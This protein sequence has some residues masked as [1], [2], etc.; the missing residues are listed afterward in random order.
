[1]A[2]VTDDHLRE[3]LAGV[4]NTTPYELWL[5]LHGPEVPCEGARVTACEEA[6]SRLGYERVPVHPI[7]LSR[8][9]FEWVRGHWP[10]DDRWPDLSDDPILL[11]IFDRYLTFRLACGA[12]AG[13]EH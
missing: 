7:R 6:L 3:L 1:M 2:A 5:M 10:S 11:E 8:D 4:G 9:G 13:M 12:G